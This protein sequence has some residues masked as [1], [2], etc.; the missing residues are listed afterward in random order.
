M[1]T[2]EPSKEP[3]ALDGPVEDWLATLKGPGAIGE[4]LGRE[5]AEQSSRG[6]VHTLREI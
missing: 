1:S 2:S 6:Y 3:E 5:P 4:L